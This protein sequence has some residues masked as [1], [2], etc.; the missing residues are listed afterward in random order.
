MSV[1]HCSQCLTLLIARIRPE[2][3]VVNA[4]HFWKAQAAFEAQIQ[5]QICQRDLCI[6]LLLA[7][8]SNFSMSMVFASASDMTG[9]DMQTSDQMEF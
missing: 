1:I 4:L 7:R 5:L 2:Y 6:A 8:N 3:T 9:H